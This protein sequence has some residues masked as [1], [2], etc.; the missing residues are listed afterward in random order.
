MIALAAPQ[1]AEAVRQALLD[2][3]AARAFITTLEATC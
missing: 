1:S 3:G 2:A